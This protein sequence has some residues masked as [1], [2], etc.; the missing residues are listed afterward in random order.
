MATPPRLFLSATSNV[1]LRAKAGQANG[2]T[3][4]KLL[5]PLVAQAHDILRERFEA[6]GS[7]EDYLYDRT[8]LADS[9]VVGLVHIASI[10]N[11]IRDRSTV[12]P[13]AAIAVGGYGRGELAPGLRPRLALSSP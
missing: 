10:S 5:R 4:R 7:A 2:P 8:K 1:P 13:L 6:G 11:G 3:R 12:A 9:T